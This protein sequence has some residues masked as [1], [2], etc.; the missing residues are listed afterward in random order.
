MTPPAAGPG[1]IARRFVERW[2]E[3]ETDKAREACIAEMTEALESSRLAGF[4]QGVEAV[5]AAIPKKVRDEYPLLVPSLRGRGMDQQEALA[6]PAAESPE[7]VV[8]DP[9]CRERAIE[10][11]MAIGPSEDEAAEL[12]D[13][14]LAAV[15]KGE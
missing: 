2:T 9:G 13:A 15:R 10:A 11:V 8:L 6:P 12:V 3:F 4:A 7:T 1:E 5:L 14:V